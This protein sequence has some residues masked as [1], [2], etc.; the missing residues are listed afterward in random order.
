L[1]D[2]TTGE[3]LNV[4]RVSA[5]QWWEGASFLPE[6]AWAVLCDS[7]A[8]IAEM[9]LEGV[10]GADVPV[11][12]N[13]APPERPGR[14]PELDR[15][16]LES[17]SAR[18]PRG[19]SPDSLVLSGGRSGIPHLLARAAEQ[20]ASVCIILGVESFL[21]QVIADHYS[22]K[23][24]L[25]S[26]ANSSGFILGEAAAAIVAVRGRRPGLALT[27]MG[28]GVEPGKDGGSKNA[29]VTGQGLTDAMRAALTSAGT[30]FHDVNVLMT[31]LNGEHY[32]FKEVAFASMRLDR[33]P[34]D[35]RSRRPR[36][37]L[38]HWNVV[39][40][41]GDVGAALMPAAMGWAFEAGRSRY[42]PGR[43][44]FTAGEDDGRRVAVVGEWQDG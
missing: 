39:E 23:R 14:D 41:I 44:M 1:S 21:R 9:N 6:L 36:G 17:L 43:V 29:P 26:S 2:L 27:G 32:K 42:L 16:L 33:L 30:A 31:D 10:V 38:E 11:L 18:L 24:R 20:E 7:R 22:R 12:I 40:T 35:G 28:L 34:P 15:S 25:L 4:F 3:L 13:V 37:H 8:L 5:H 19:L